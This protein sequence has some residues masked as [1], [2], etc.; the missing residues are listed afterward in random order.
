MDDL[1]VLRAL[2]EEYSPSGDEQRAVRR[3]TDVATARGFDVRIDE[4]GNAIARIGRGSP[5]IVF[6]G[7]IDTVDGALPVRLEG[8]RLHG[9]GTC[10]AK[11]SLAAAVIA[12]SRHRGPGEIVVVGAVGEEHDSRGTRH[13]LMSHP[14]PVFL[15]VGAPS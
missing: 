9:R 14:A 1:E 3:F 2:V 13:L 5:R 6:L 15:I 7:H 8:G 11:G 12:A 4:V 10:D